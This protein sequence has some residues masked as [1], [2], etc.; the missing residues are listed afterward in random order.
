V[1]FEPNDGTELQRLHALH[2]RAK[3]AAAAIE[4]GD[5]VDDGPLCV[6]LTNEGLR[7]TDSFVTFQELADVLRHLA[8]IAGAVQDPLTMSEKLPAA[9]AGEPSAVSEPSDSA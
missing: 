5:V 2:T 4:R 6:W 7:S 1:L 8:G 3:H 9:L